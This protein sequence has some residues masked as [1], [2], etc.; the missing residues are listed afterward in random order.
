MIDVNAT[1]TIILRDT[2]LKTLSLDNLK[3][4]DLF[5]RLFFIRFQPQRNRYIRKTLSPA[6]PPEIDRGSPG[7]RPE[8]WRLWL[9]YR[10][11]G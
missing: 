7:P 8:F 3:M 11:F 10:R 2:A 6:G 5:V 1:G 4:L 9:Y